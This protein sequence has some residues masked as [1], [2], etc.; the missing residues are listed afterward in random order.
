MAHIVGVMGGLGP[1]AT[2]DFF[3][4]VLAATPAETDQDHIHLL[5]DC[6]PT[7]PNRNDAIAGRGPSPG[8]GLCAMAQ[9][10][11]RA[12]ATYVVMV[13]NTAHYWQ[14]DIQAALDIP[15]LSLIDMTA[16]RVKESGATAA[17]V[18][19]AEGC[20]NAH[21]YDTALIAR[22]IRPILPT[23]H[24]QATFMSLLYRIKRGDTTAD[25]TRGMRDLALAQQAR[26]AEV[27]IAAC[28][29]VPLVLTS[30]DVP[31][32]VISSTD[33]LVEAIVARHHA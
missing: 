1:A 28:T 8:P 12:G 22:G 30:N 18:L 10:L 14:P 29:E 9:R 4:K 25:M 24:E 7:L 15:F 33:V 6:D 31:F 16:D 27:C 21:L 20:L 3:A 19:A 11:E 17:S 23:E 5:I 32:P 13:C 2:A 26:G